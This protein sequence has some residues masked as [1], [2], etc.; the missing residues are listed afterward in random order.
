[1]AKLVLR[2]EIGKLGA[3]ILLAIEWEGQIALSLVH[4]LFM[5]SSNQCFKSELV[6]I[7]CDL[8]LWQQ[9][10]IPYLRKEEEQR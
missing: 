9:L 8:L 7:L 1:M 5:K 4:C 10:K 6:M 2:G 3:Y